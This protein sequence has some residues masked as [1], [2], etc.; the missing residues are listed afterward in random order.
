LIDH[1]PQEAMTAR[2]VS[3]TAI[4]LAANLLGT[5]STFRNRGGTVSGFGQTVYAASI[6]SE[7]KTRVAAARAK[8]PSES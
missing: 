7:D 1:A 5:K 4:L 2:D 8:K 3:N 6:L